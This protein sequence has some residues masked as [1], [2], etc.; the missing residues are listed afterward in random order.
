[1]IRFACPLCSKEYS[2]TFDSA[3]QR[4]DC[5]QCGAI[6]I[7]P[8]KTLREIVHGIELPGPVDKNTSPIKTVTPI[9][10]TTGLPTPK[11]VEKPFVFDEVPNPRPRKRN[12]RRYSASSTPIRRYRR[13]GMVT[14]V[15]IVHL[16][17][18]LLAVLCGST[19]LLVG[20]L[21]LSTKSN[22]GPA[23][24]VISSII[25]VVVYCLAIPDLIVAYGVWNRHYWGRTCGIIMACLNGLFALASIFWGDICSLAIDGFCCVFS[26]VVLLN[27]RYTEEFA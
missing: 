25:A 8:E 27:P 11:S 4:Q 10:M 3:G 24:G 2:A 13:S 20:G 17:S 9:R 6:V 23:M 19:L 7:I 26:L 14:A 21:L 12:R 15:A 22:D 1:M 18:G 16:F 5:I